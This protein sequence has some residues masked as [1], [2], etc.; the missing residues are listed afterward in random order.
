MALIFGW[1]QKM[2]DKE[3]GR[4]YRMVQKRISTNIRPEI[5]EILKPFSLK[6]QI[7]K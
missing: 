2:M 5:Q 3:Y 1:L 4:L 7:K 6:V